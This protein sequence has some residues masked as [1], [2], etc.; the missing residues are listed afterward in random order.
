[1]FFQILMY[2]MCWNIRGFN[3]PSKH[4]EIR[5]VLLS[6]K[7]NVCGILETKVSINDIFSV[8]R[9]VMS[10]WNFIHNGNA[11]QNIRALVLW[12]AALWKVKLLFSSCQIMLV[13]ISSLDTRVQ[14]LV[15]YVYGDKSPYKRRS[16]ESILTI[17]IIA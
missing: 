13:E 17:L 15:A 4:I 7:V 10:L 2:N 6:N 16:C 8:C 5:N 1:M 3:H 9:N 11:N 14:A 12:N